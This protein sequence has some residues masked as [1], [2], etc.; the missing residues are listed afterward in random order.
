MK[1]EAGMQVDFKNQPGIVGK[2]FSRQLDPAVFPDA[3]GLNIQSF[4]F[5]Q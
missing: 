5:G 1:R 2:R 3:I 4:L